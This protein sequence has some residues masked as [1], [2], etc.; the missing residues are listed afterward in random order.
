[1]KKAISAQELIDFLQ[2]KANELEGTVILQ[3]M[4]PFNEYFDFKAQD[5]NTINIG[6]ILNK[7]YKLGIDRGV[8]K[9]KTDI[10]T[11]IGRLLLKEN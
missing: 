7:V 11:E 4:V 9:G 5:I 6:E 2:K 3:D 10:C 1:M 8:V